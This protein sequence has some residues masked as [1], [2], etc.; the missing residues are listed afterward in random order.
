MNNCSWVVGYHG[1]SSKVAEDIFSGKVK[2]LEE[3]KNDYDWLGNGIYFWENSY[4]R[5]KKW[6][7]EVISRKKLH[8]ETPAVIGAIIIPNF[9]LD[10][11]RL[12]DVLNL[13]THYKILKELAALKGFSENDFPKNEKAHSRD[14]DCKLRKLDCFVISSLHAY[15]QAKKME[16]YDSVRGAFSEG[17]PIFPNSLI[18]EKNH[19]QWAIRN[20]E[21]CIL[22]YFRPILKH[23]E[24]N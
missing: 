13:K 16:S 12:E 20:P 4:Q 11:T 21:K 8:D 1:C 7:E 6:A 24:S 23:T 17:L 22:G 15:R 5:A 18:T 2:H 19:I 3:S 9:C 14:I 10:L